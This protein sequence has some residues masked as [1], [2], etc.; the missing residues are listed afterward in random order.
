[1]RQAQWGTRLFAYRTLCATAR[2]VQVLKT[3]HGRERILTQIFKNLRPPAQ[4]L[5]LID[6][7]LANLAHVA[8]D[9]FG[10]GDTS[11]TVAPRW[12]WLPRK[13]SKLEYSNLEYLIAVLRLRSGLGSFATGCPRS[14]RRAPSARASG[15]CARGS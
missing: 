2:T 6:T 4:R 8:D 5:F 1:M 14:V 12:I 7:E 3:K 9:R 11:T 15:P 13:Y 10:S